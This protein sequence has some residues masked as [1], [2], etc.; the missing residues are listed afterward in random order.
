MESAEIVCID[1]NVLVRFRVEDHAA[2]QQCRAA[3]NLFRRQTV[4]ISE[5]VL[6]ETEW[7]L[8]AVYAVPRAEIHSA[9]TQLMRL[10]QVLFPDRQLLRQV[11]AYFKAGFDF[12]D[13]WHLLRGEG[14]ELK[15]FDAQFIKKARESGHP[16]SSP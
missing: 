7:V 9:F 10:R 14:Y 16:A 2:P 3:K 8:R 4:F 5:S 12:A 11:F 1:T 6:L 15:T 13:A